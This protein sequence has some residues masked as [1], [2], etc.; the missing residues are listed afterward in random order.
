MS[1]G[2]N[3]KRQSRCWSGWNQFLNPLGHLST[4]EHDPE[5]LLILWA[6]SSLATLCIVCYRHAV[7]D[8]FGKFVRTFFNIHLLVLCAWYAWN[9]HPNPPPIVK[10]CKWCMHIT[11]NVVVLVCIST[12]NAWSKYSSG[13]NYLTV[14]FF[15]CYMLVLRYSIC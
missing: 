2:Q 14:W 3:C 10:H 6:L 12:G 1:K 4:W 5:I 9:F 7:E 15:A 8:Y 13:K 11:S